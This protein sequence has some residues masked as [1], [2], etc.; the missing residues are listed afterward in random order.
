MLT[1]VRNLLRTLDTVT[2][3]HGGKIQNKYVLYKKYLL[4]GMKLHILICNE[5]WEEPCSFSHKKIL[6]T[7]LSPDF[8]KKKK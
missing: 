6:E 7:G 1:V 5:V 8:V 2:S 3:I 4:Y